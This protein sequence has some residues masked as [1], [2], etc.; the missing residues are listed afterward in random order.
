MTD[1]EAVLERRTAF[2]ARVATHSPGRGVVVTARDTLELATVLVR[3]GKEVELAARCRQHF[4]LALSPGPR[5]S[6][7]R[8]MA[9]IGTGPGAWLATREG[10]QHDFV[11]TLKTALSDVVSISDQSDGYAV[12][13]LSGTNARETL[14]KMLPID[15]HPSVFP[16][17]SVAVTQAGH[18]GTTVWRLED[19]Q[20][21]GPVFEM[22]VY[23]S[24]ARDFWQFL[25]ESAAEFG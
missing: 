4:G 20:Q 16:S 24:F 1:V 7:G 21:V 10:G 5:R 14:A 9:W 6:A 11:R 13:R 3:K 25:S 23:R 17:G 12:L 2:H 15:L 19:S 18:I 22:A 8:E